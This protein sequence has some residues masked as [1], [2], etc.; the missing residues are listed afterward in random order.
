MKLLEGGVN[1]DEKDWYNAVDS[2]ECYNAIAGL[3][4]K[5]L[6]KNIAGAIESEEAEVT[7]FEQWKDVWRGKGSNFDMVIS[8]PLGSDGDPL[9]ISFSLL[10][11]VEKYISEGIFT[12]DCREGEED[13]DKKKHKAAMLNIADSFAELSTRLRAAA[14]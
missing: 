12:F 8:L 11:S 2:Q 4:A 9:Y 7:F 10:G 14:E 5:I 3:A 1:F 13:R 6:E